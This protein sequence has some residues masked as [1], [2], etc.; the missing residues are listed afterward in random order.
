VQAPQ[1]F[2]GAFAVELSVWTLFGG[3]LFFHGLSL[4]SQVVAGCARYGPLRASCSS[5]FDSFMVNGGWLGCWLPLILL[6]TTIACRGAAPLVSNIFGMACGRR[7]GDQVAHERG[8]I[9]GMM[10]PCYVGVQIKAVVLLQWLR[11][12]Y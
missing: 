9:M 5:D 2:I 7:G 12:Q 8:L 4:V 10:E 6:Q 1:L 11:V 3:S